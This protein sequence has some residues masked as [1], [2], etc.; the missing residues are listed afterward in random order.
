[1]AKPKVFVT[2]IIRDAGL[3]LVNDFCDAEVWQG[4]LPPSRE[5]MLEKVRGMDGLLCLL[6]DRIDGELL[7][8]AGSQLKVVSNHA[9]GFDNVVVPDATVRRI[10]VGNT[11]GILTDATADF[12]FALLMSAARRVTEGER[13]LRAGK[14]KT[15][16]PSILLGA[17]F[18]GKTLGLVGFGRI[19]RAVAKRAAGFDMRV[20]Y[21]D[22]NSA[23]DHG[24]TPVDSLDQLL[25]E[26]DFVSL[27]TP[28]ND[29]TRHMVNAEFLGKMKSNAILVNT[30]R[31]PVV[32]QNALYQALKSNQIFAAALD[33]TDP[34]PLPMDSPLLTLENC[35][36]APHIASASE[37]TRDDMARLAANNL[38][39]G[40][41]GERLPHCVNP[42][43]YNPK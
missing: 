25:R 15:W 20:I 11:P 21:Y 4:D 30:S 36:I 9:V 39:A 43:V 27:H 2:R 22:R 40:L 42:D 32:D 38:I 29:S 41:K 19:G 24:A 8:A 1:M 17:D 26:S 33:V 34:E 3:T 7:D 35:L 31:G 37:K 5:V 28:L 12:A 10:P 6:T 13:Y 23:P 16:G 14:W 18:V